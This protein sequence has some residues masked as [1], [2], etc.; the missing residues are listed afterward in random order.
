LLRARIPIGPRPPLCKELAGALNPVGARTAAGLPADADTT[1]VV[2]FALQGLGM[3]TS[4]DPLWGYLDDNG[5]FRTWL[6]GEANVSVSTNAHVLE[7]LATQ[8]GPQTHWPDRREKI[9]SHLC[10]LLRD[11][12]QAD[13]SWQDRWHAS[14]FYPTACCAPLLHE[15]DPDARPAVDRAVEWVRQAQNTDGSWGIYGGS[16]EESAYAMQILLLTGHHDTATAHRGYEYLVHRVDQ[17]S[18]QHPALWHDKDLYCPYTI[19]RASILATLHLAATLGVD[20]RQDQGTREHQ[21]PA[22]PRSA[23]KITPATRLPR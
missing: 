20:T 5:H 14:P 6:A 11:L 3:D 9:L 17:P 10:R 19:V 21:D 1:A 13:G 23:W 22:T 2:L 16:A 8:S 4:A 18:D 15:I 7:T 12:Q